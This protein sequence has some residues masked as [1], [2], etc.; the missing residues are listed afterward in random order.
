MSENIKNPMRSRLTKTALAGVISSVALVGCGPEFDSKE[1]VF[2]VECPDEE[3]VE[4]VS[5]R[6][7]GY[8]NARSAII[9]IRCSSGATAESIVLFDSTNTDFSEPDSVAVSIDYVTSN[10]LNSG[11]R[12]SPS[13]EINEDESTVEL[14]VS[15]ISDLKSVYIAG[16]SFASLGGE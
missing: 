4:V 10:F 8:G 13:F 2:G 15:E 9:D 5:A 16:Q 6:A 7:E 14:K 3:G 1:F 11:H 12:P